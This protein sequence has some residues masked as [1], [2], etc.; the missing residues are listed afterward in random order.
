MLHCYTPDLELDVHLD[1]S[2]LDT[3]ETQLNK[4]IIQIKSTSLS[5]AVWASSSRRPILLSVE[6]IPRV[7]FRDF[8]S[9]EEVLVS[10]FFSSDFH[11]SYIECEIPVC[12]RLLLGIHCVF[13]I[14]FTILWKPNS[15]SFLF[16]SLVKTRRLLEAANLRIISKLGLN[17]LKVF[18][19][20]A[21]KSLLAR[22][23]NKIGEL[24]IYR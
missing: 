7:V 6:F 12:W 17:R 23:K 20:R 5:R 24:K 8:F 14:L 19:Y 4:I 16:M 1:G 10:N 13:D 22:S 2:P 18:N 3:P 21:E 15:I 11:P 9:S